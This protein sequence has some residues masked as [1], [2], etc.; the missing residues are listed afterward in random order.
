MGYM[1]N[2][3]IAA[4][5]LFVLTLTGRAQQKVPNAVSE[6]STP[7]AQGFHDDRYGISFGT[8]AG[9]Q[10]NRRDGEVSTFE[11]DAPTA[12]PGTQMRAAVSIGFN[13]FPRSTFAG[14][15]FYYSI[16]PKVKPDACANQASAVAPRTVSF[17]PIGGKKFTHGYNEHGVI[18]TESRDE[19][20]TMP[21]HNVCYRF[22]LVINTFCGGEVSGAQ[23]I[24]Q[25]QIEAVRG[26][27]ENILSTVRF[28]NK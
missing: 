10:L 2:N 21:T 27:L 7:A 8:P 9:W 15:Y 12:S 1:C 18:C 22:D 17:E 28:D 16:T 3:W 19:I 23:D 6:P 20:Y 11:L 26:R 5:L 4:N 14:A 13:P 24:S 25:Q